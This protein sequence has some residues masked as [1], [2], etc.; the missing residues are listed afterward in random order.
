MSHKGVVGLIV[1]N[2]EGIKIMRFIKKPDESE[3]YIDDFIFIIYLGIPIKSTLENSLS[4]QYAAQ[5]TQMVDKTRSMIKE[6]DN[7]NDLT[8]IRL[9]TKKH[10]VLVC[11]EKEY[12]MIVIQNPIDS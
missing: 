7:N 3:S 6:L 4:V 12:S 8:F 10:E 11:P 5:V 1:I 9:R 2:H